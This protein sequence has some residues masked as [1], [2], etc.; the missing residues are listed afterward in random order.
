MSTI[1]IVLLTGLSL[2]AF[3]SNSLL[4]RIALKQTQIDPASFTSIRLVAGALT[5]WFITSL[6]HTSKTGQGNWV[7]A[8]ALF[9]YAAAF[10]FAYNSLSAGTGALILFAA[11]QASMIGYGLWQGERFQ[12]GQ[13][14]GLG[15]ALLGLV[16]LMLPGL[17]APPIGAALLMLSAGAAWGVYS[18]RGRKGGDPSKVSAGNFLRSVPLALV[19]SAL[20]YP[21][22][23]VDSAGALYAVLSGTLTSGLGY[24]VWYSVLPHLRASNAAT[25]QLSVPVIAAL[26]GIL[27]LGEP[28][29]WRLVGASLAILGGIALVLLKRK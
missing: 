17:A 10:S 21:Y 3:A 29:S 28:L 1:R 15:I 7:S 11:V 6:N 4:C 23:E 16:G 26:G 5:L 18:L 8:L 27:F 12:V 9:I 14:L 22:S 25:L 24:I 19:L 20:W 2:L 13:W